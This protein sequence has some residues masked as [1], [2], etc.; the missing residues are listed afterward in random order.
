[1]RT[2]IKRLRVIIREEIER[3]LDEDKLGIHSEPAMQMVSRERSASASNMVDLVMR[4]G[5]GADND[6]T[7]RTLETI[8]ARMAASGDT[9]LSTLSGRVREYARAVQSGRVDTGSGSWFDFITKLGGLV[10]KTTSGKERM[11]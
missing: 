9:R 3:A 7:A 6:T 11:N 8:A 4:L 10:R 2:T 5:S 1:M